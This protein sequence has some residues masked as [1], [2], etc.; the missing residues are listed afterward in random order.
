MKKTSNIL[1][2]KDESDN[3]SRIWH[4]I[5]FKIRFELFPTVFLALL[6][7]TSVSLECMFSELTTAYRKF[8]LSLLLQNLRR[9][10]EARLFNYSLFGQEH[11]ILHQY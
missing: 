3:I 2:I 1:D 10:C 6:Y 8:L 9:V 5:S 4:Q 7:L 11:T